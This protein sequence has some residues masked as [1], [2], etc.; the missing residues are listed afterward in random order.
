VTVITE[1]CAEAD[2]WATAFTVMGVTQSK[3]LANQLGIA[4]Y[5]L[6][7]QDDDF[8]AISSHNFE[9]FTD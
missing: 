6:V 4:A 7:R 2:A 1:S 9:P 8:V 5:M 3:A